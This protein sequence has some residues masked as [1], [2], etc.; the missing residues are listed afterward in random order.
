MM[1]NLLETLS[2]EEIGD[3]FA[4]LFAGQLGAHLTSPHEPQSESDNE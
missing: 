4:F 2:L 1:E 3:L